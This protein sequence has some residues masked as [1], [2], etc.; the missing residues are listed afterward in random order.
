[1]SGQAALFDLERKARRRRSD[2]ISS[3]WA[4]Q[5]IDVS[6]SEGL[7]LNSLVSGRGTSHELHQR[8]VQRGHRITPQRVRTA[9]KELESRG[10]THR[11]GEYGLSEHGGKS[12][13][14]SR[15]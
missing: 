15:A 4:A 2:P 1:M 7:V 12:E 10:L 13:V 9:L 11:T 8:I 5:G 3:F 14:W 6:A